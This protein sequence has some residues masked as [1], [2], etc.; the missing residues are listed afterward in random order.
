MNIDTVNFGIYRITN[1]DRGE[2]A[3]VL[4]T[5]TGET[6]HAGRTEFRER[7]KTELPEAVLADIERRTR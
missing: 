4:N 6:F 2:N 5:H 1:I 7:R 3:L